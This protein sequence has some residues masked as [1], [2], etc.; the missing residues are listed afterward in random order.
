MDD[1]ASPTELDPKKGSKA[2]PRSFSAF[3]DLDD[4][5]LL[6]ID[7]IVGNPK[8]NPPIPALVP[9]GRS[10]WWTGVKTGR[11]PKPIKLGARTTVWRKSDI[12]VLL[13][14]EGL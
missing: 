9:V 11:F 7:Q 14:S 13:K 8:A 10:T 2:R 1:D 4:S 12:L 3:Q 6:R 5:A